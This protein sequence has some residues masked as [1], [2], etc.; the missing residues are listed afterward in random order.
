[1]VSNYDR[2]LTEI[3][4]EAKRVSAENGLPSKELVDLVMEIV[5]LVDRNRIQPVHAIN[6]KVAR[7]ISQVAIQTL[8]R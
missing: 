4:S 1:M 3:T 2:I 6:Q 8:E 5:D 7:M